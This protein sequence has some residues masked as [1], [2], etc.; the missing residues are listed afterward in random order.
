[1]GPL[2]VRWL[3]RQALL[4]AALSATLTCSK[5]FCPQTCSCSDDRVFCIGK[6]LQSI[7]RALPP[8]TLDLYL[9]ANHL[10][11]VKASSFQGLS[12]LSSLDLSLN[13][14]ADLPPGIFNSLAHLNNLDLT[15]NQLTLGPLKNAALAA[16][17]R[18]RTLD[19]SYTG[20]Q[21]TERGIFDDLPDL[22]E[23][24]L[25][26]N[27]FYCDC[28]LAWLVHWLVKVLCV[29]G[30]LAIDCVPLL[31]LSNQICNISFKLPSCCSISDVNVSGAARQRRVD[32]YADTSS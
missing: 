15:G 23:L 27:L 2:P 14:I 29:H 12:R 8:T 4:L 28:R 20:Q 17:P 30:K 9:F 31:C 19:L 10:S 7:P 25:A 1:M 6:D 32:C 26:G 5:Y 24:G 13:R 3:L 16:L 18:L 11:Q 21:A 22:R